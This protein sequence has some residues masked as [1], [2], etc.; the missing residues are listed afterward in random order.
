M[1]QASEARFTTVFIAMPSRGFPGV[2]VLLLVDGWLRPKALYC[3]M[4]HGFATWLNTHA[5]R[6][7]SQIRRSDQ[8]RC[9]RCRASSSESCDAARS[10]LR[11]CLSARSKRCVI[12]S[13][14]VNTAPP[15]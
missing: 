10:L 14:P 3:K 2:S 13:E 12:W 9:T 4:I 6:V 11:R 15:I 5:G 1:Y 7:A 8:D